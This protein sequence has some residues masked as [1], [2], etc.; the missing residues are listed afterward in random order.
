[1]VDEKFDLE[2]VSK[3]KNV[4]GIDEVGRG[5]LAGPVVAAAVKLDRQIEGVDDSKRLSAKK[6]EEMVEKIILNAQ[7]AFGIATPTEIDLYNIIGATKLAMQRAYEKLNLQAF[8]LIDGLE[9]GFDFPHESI[10]KGD[11]KSP[12]IASASI[13][14]KVFRDEIM[15]KLS[16]FFKGYGFEHNVGYATKQH[17]QAIKEKGPTLFHRL[18]FQPVSE[19]ITLELLERWKKDEKISDQRLRGKTFHL[20]SQ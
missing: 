20:F 9:M 4:V 17:L 2:Y 19:A 16:P 11:G 8:A 7:V 13:V 15:K 5:A 18:T 6:R 1:M 10:V 12:S 14:A 3:Y